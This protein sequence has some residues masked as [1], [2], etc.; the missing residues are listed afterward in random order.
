LE[1]LLLKKKKIVDAWDGC[2]IS[3]LF[4]LPFLFP[5]Y[6]I[7]KESYGWMD[8]WMGLIWMSVCAQYDKLR[9][10]QLILTKYNK[11]IRDSVA[12]N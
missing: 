12:G 9:S 5:F 4:S 1:A 10:H 7:S 3:S 11:E 6:F 8:G 2:S